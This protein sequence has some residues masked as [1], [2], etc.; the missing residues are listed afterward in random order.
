MDERRPRAAAVPGDRTKLDDPSTRSAPCLPTVYRIR[1]RGHLDDRWLALVG[2]LELLREKRGDTVLTVPIADQAA[3]H[4]LLRTLRDLGV[5][6]ISVGPAAPER[7]R[8]APRREET[9]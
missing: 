5:P 7:P 9:S 4:G 3:L 2:G 6:L 1:V 8:G